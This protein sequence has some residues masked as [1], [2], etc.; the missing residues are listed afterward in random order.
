[1][2]HR[3]LGPASGPFAGHRAR[4]VL[5]VTALVST[6]IGMGAAPSAAAATPLTVALLGD[7]PYS[8]TH[9]S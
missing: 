7:T 4:R 2:G 5:L 6:L 1:M 3:R 9:R 8:N